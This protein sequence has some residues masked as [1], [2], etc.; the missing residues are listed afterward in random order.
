[1]VPVS[2]FLDEVRCNILDKYIDTD[3]NDQNTSLDAIKN[4]HIPVI[5]IA[6]VFKYLVKVDRL[7]L[8]VTLVLAL[9][10]AIESCVL[11]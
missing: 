10:I 6:K 5:F 2:D 3:D 7:A 4:D 11:V 9:S 8:T 1:M